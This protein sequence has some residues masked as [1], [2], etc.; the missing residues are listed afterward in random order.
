MQ[1]S[2][3][4]PGYLLMYHKN[5]TDWPTCIKIIQG[6]V[7]VVSMFVLSSHLASVRLLY[8]NVDSL[9]YARISV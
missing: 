3:G 9:Y 6:G 2:D 4:T 1:V 8:A 5:A 7:L